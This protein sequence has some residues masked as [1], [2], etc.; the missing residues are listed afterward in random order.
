MSVYLSMLFTSNYISLP[1]AT[2]Q[3]I[4]KEYYKLV[5]PV[6]FFIL[7]E[8]PATE[9]VIQES[10]LRTLEKSYQLQD[11]RRM[12]G[13]LRM[14]ARSVALNYLRKLKRNRT[15]LETD[16]VFSGSGT[17]PGVVRPSLEEEVEANLMKEDIRKYLGLL[18]PEYRQLIE[19]RWYSNLSYR[20][21][22]AALGTTENVVRQK[23]YR[24]REA[25]RDKLK[26]N[27][28]GVRIRR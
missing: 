27:W 6:I 5:Y 17:P 4:Y 10:F 1:K 22:A 26:E 8:Y 12:E 2:Q 19:M 18:K 13:W 25:V 21:M 24:A 14:V 23:L 15:E 7:Q 9:D 20:E 28:E 16:E 3:E 11:I